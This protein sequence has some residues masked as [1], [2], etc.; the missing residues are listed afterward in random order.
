MQQPRVHSQ[1]A[2]HPDVQKS[3]LMAGQNPYAEYTELELDW[4]KSDL[5]RLGADKAGSGA[6][7]A[8]LGEIMGDEAGLGRTR[9]R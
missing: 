1:P 2:R 6:D 4:I 9:L 5:D 7:Q 3:R 8:G